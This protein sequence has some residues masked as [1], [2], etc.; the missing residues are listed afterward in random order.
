MHAPHPKQQPD[1]VAS[2]AKRCSIVR[3]TNSLRRDDARPGE[4]ERA[5]YAINDEWFTGDAP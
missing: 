3:T 1:P 4:T 5:S 2:C